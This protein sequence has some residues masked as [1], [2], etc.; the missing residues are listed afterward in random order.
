MILRKNYNVEFFDEAYQEPPINNTLFGL[1]DNEDGNIAF[2][3]KTDKNKWI[4]TV[5]NPDGL[6]LIF[7]VIDKGVIKDDEYSGY[8]RCDGMLTS[9]KHLCFIEL[10]KERKNWIP[11]GIEQ[12]GSTIR[13]FDEAH[14]KRKDLYTNR[15]AYVCN[16]RHPHFHRINNEERKCFL[17]TYGFRLYIDAII[18]LRIVA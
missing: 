4:A 16:K 17:M 7:T 12:L 5:E 2:T 10:K 11:E 14:P 13:L 6:T 8:R 18:S 9:S 15:E 3:D 1:C